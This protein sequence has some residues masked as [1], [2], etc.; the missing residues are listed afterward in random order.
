MNDSM[1]VWENNCLTKACWYAV[2][3]VEM[4]MRVLQMPVCI[5]ESLDQRRLTKRLI[6]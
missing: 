2:V 1:E 6:Y 4:R 3:D 5:E